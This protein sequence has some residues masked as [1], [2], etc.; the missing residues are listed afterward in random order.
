LQ[1]LLQRGGIRD[2]VFAIARKIA[3]SKL[4]IYAEI[5]VE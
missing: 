2:Q 5:S 1:G 4:A 3:E